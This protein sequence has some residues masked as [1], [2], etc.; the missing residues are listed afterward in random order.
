[1]D[2]G[3]AAWLLDCNTFILHTGQQRIDSLKHVSI[4]YIVTIPYLT[5]G[6]SFRTFLSILAGTM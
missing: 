3:Y 5:A 1:M 2:L 6:F 4:Y